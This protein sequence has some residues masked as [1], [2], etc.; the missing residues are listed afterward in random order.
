MTKEAYEEVYEEV[1][2]ERWK[3]RSVYDRPEEKLKLLILNH[4]GES[5]W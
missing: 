1:Y 4:K 5:L 3:I 2:E